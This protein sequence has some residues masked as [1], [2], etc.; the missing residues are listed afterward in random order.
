[1]WS[2]SNTDLVDIHQSPVVANMNQ[3]DQRENV[4][5]KRAKREI[6]NMNERRRMQNINSGFHKLRVLLPQKHNG[7]KLSKA[8]ILQQTA[9]YIYQLEKEIS[10]LLS[11]NAK[12]KEAIGSSASASGLND[13]TSPSEWVSRFSSEP[14]DCPSCKRRKYDNNHRHDIDSSPLGGDGSST[15]SSSEQEIK[16]RKASKTNGGTSATKRSSEYLRKQLSRVEKQLDEE[17]RSRYMLE[18]ELDLIHGKWNGNNGA[19]V[20]ASSQYSSNMDQQSVD[21]VEVATE[22]IEIEMHSCPTSPPDAITLSALENENKPVYLAPEHTLPSQSQSIQSIDHHHQQQQQHRVQKQN[23]IA[24]PIDVPFV[25]PTPINQCDT[26][27]FSIVATN[28]GPVVVYLGS[29]SDSCNLMSLLNRTKL[30]QQS[31]SSQNNETS[32]NANTPQ[33]QLDTSMIENTK[34]ST[35]VNRPANNVSSSSSSSSTSS[36]SDSGAATDSGKGSRQTLD[37]IVEAIKHLEGDHYFDQ[38]SEK[39]GKDQSPLK[40]KKELITDSNGSIL[41]SQFVEENP[42]IFVNDSKINVNKCDNIVNLNNLPNG[43]TGMI[44]ISS[45]TNQS[46][47]QT[48]PQI[49]QLQRPNVIVANSIDN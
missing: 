16:S 14:P 3:G 34:L 30:Q 33:V 40:F 5:E 19:I 11:Q 28:N 47:T 7:E 21:E 17:R 15:E 12:L 6:A 48:R 22:S 36:V 39:N 46:T 41:L 29:D 2:P 26:K 9:N 44:P 49:I 32:K 27:N 10:M 20:R 23:A 18:E 25:A 35:I 8:A 45:G 1:M 37:T 4:E 38:F 43:S 31:T 42:N 24:L 13:S